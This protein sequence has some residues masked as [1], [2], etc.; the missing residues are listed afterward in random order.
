MFVFVLFKNKKQALAMTLVLGVLLFMIT[1]T[2]LPL[3]AKGLFKSVKYEQ[4]EALVLDRH[5]RKFEGD[6]SW[7]EYRFT[8]GGREYT[9]RAD[10]PYGEPGE[11]EDI[12]VNVKDFSDVRY[13][14]PPKTMN[15]ALLP[16]LVIAPLALLFVITLLN[17]LSVSKKE[18]KHANP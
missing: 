2:M 6:S 9:A 4:V 17:Y 18:K 7:T 15:A 1:A 12:Y 10:A 13:N 14:T 16:W 11:T 8:Y 3:A 5:V